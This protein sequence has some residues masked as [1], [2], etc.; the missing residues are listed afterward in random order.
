ML[1]LHEVA[2]VTRYDVLKYGVVLVL[3]TVFLFLSFHKTN[4]VYLHG[5]LVTMVLPVQT[6]CDENTFWQSTRGNFKFCSI[7]LK[8]SFEPVLTVKDNALL[9][10]CAGYTA[11]LTHLLTYTDSY[12]EGWPWRLPVLF[13]H[14]TYTLH[15]NSLHCYSIISTECLTFSTKYIWS[16]FMSW[17]KVM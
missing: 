7:A 9:W 12:T 13:E 15:K 5:E 14:F 1:L 16:P 8:V 10:Y 17:T 11:F 2:L 4:H 3:F 6:V